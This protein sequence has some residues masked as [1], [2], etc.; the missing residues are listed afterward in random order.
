MMRLAALWTALLVIVALSA[1]KKAAPPD[2]V[3]NYGP[4]PASSGV[5]AGQGGATT[6]ALTDAYLYVL[7]AAGRPVGSAHVN[8]VLPPK[9]GQYQL[10]ANHSVHTAAVESATLTKCPTG[11]VLV[12]GSTDEYYYV[13]DDT[14][15]Q[16]ATAHVGAGLSL[17]QGSYQI[18]LNNSTSAAQVQ[19][20]TMA[21][22]TTGTVSVDAPTDEY[23]YVFDS[24]GTQ[25]ASSHL[26]K[27]VG[28]FAGTY[29]VKV[30]NTES[31]ADVHAD[32]ASNI[33][34]GTLV[35]EGATDEYYYVFNTAGTQLASAHLGRPLAL[36]PGSY[37]VKLNNS[38]ATTSV[39]TSP[40]TIGSGSL[41]LQG[42]TDEY[43]YVFDRAGTQL[44]STHL[45][46]PLSFLPG[47]YIAKLNNVSVPVHVE[48]GRANDQQTGSLTVKS[49]GSGEYSVSD[50]AGTQL[51]SKQL[52]QP[53]SLPA[54][55]YSVKV[56]T[57]TRT[58][59]VRAGQTS[60]VNL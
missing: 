58:V 7:D 56:G 35:L 1:C 4:L 32:E 40:V 3:C 21:N 51:A 8:R 14:G 34:A 17:F 31:K 11:G 49:S 22:L 38:P 29:T 37:N 44:A 47:D 15:K 26:G 52:N 18:R 43:Y 27:P 9:P 50:S 48:V 16:L 55:E 39:G 53:V 24:A 5:P 46:R 23:Y 20:G 10:E 42:S 57:N 28:V 30:N 60:A 45:G 33:P 36:L 13:F 6:Q 41:M 25:L 12:K 54:G 2:N 59:A 19:S